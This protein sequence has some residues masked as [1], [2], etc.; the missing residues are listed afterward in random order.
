MLGGTMRL[1]FIQ[2]GTR[3]KQDTEENWYTGNRKTNVKQ[4]TVNYL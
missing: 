3:L 2:G 4:K 1:L